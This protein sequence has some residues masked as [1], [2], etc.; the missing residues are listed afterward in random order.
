MGSHEPDESVTSFALLSY[1][2]GM[3]RNEEN[4]LWG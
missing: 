1:F 4:K 3:R 2:Y